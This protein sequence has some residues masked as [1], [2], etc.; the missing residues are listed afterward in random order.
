VAHSIHLRGGGDVRRRQIVLIFFGEDLEKINR[1]RH[2]D[3]SVRHAGCPALSRAHR[4]RGKPQLPQ[5][6]GPAN[7]ISG[8]RVFHQF[9]LERLKTLI[10]QPVFFPPPHKLGKV[11]ERQ[12]HTQYYS[13]QSV[14]DKRKI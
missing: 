3:I 6:A 10:A 11:N 1:A 9:R 7:E 14:W 8:Q 4:R 2:A 13:I 5:A 12:F